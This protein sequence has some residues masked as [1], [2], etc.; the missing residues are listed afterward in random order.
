MIPSACE[1]SMLFS[2]A[3]VSWLLYSNDLSLSD[4]EFQN[5]ECLTAGAS[6]FSLF[7]VVTFSQLRLQVF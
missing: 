5:A 1:K 4:R 6:K 3:F 2:S 7:T